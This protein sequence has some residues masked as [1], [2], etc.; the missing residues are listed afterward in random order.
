MVMELMS[1]ILASLL[2]LV[3][4]QR[5]LVTAVVAETDGKQR[6]DI[7]VFS[8]RYNDIFPRQLPSP[9]NFKPLGGREARFLEVGLPTCNVDAFSTSE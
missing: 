5:G 6:S 3:A 7:S 9:A 4:L 1:N 8:S 2:L